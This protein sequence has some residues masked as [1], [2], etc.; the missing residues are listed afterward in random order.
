VPMERAVV[1]VEGGRIVGTAAAIPFRMS[2]PGG[3]VPTAGITA[4]GVVP[5]HR[6]QGVLGRMMRHQLDDVH[7]R[8]EPAAALWASEGSIY[9]RYGYGL[10]AL[11][12][13]LRVG[14]P[15]GRFHRDPWWDGRVE[16]IGE[17]PAATLLP[18]V[19]ERSRARRPGMMSRTE[20]WWRH[21]VLAPSP[22]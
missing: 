8:G 1:A 19:Y 22:D 18:E 15:W 9:G 6:R 5:T 3:D 17:E 11:D 7:A 21:R 13:H 16:L 12:A 10:A 4:V 2:A 14:A 20:G